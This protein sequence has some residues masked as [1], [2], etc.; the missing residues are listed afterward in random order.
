[1]RFLLDEHLPTGL[2]TL[3]SELGSDALHVKTEGLLSASDGDLWTLA[4]KLD[5]T[6]VSKD[7]DFLAMAQRDGRRAGLVHLNLGNISN[8]EL[9]MAVRASWPQVMEKLLS[10]EPVVELRP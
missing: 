4:A 6:V 3:I 1:M 10:G 5:A 2:A 7:S 8:R 9:Y